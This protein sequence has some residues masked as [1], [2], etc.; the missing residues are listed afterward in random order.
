MLVQGIIHKLR[1][2]IWDRGGGESDMVENLWEKYQL[3]IYFRFIV[4]STS[5]SIKHI[6]MKNRNE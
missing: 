4:T 1:S 5:S 2:T 3:N 6:S